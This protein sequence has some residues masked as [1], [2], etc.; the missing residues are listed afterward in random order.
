MIKQDYKTRGQER[1]EYLE[2]KSKVDMIFCTISSV[3]I[4]TVMVATFG[5][6]LWG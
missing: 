3:M 6:F 4:I 5:G 2:W 1:R